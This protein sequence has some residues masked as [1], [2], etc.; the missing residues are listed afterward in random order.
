M[1]VNCWAGVNF[2]THCPVATLL[3]ARLL[4]LPLAWVLNRISVWMALPGPSAFS[5]VPTGGVPCW[6]LK[7][8]SRRVALRTSPACTRPC[9]LKL[10]KEEA[11]LA[12]SLPTTGWVAPSELS[13]ARPVAVP[14]A[15]LV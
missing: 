7:Q 13:R 15:H 14:L 11:G 8:E 9:M 2:I 1:P 12:A 5:F 4:L 6:L 10:K 3:G